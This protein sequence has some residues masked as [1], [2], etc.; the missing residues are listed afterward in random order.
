MLR[1]D[2]LSHVEDE[3]DRLDRR[4][5]SRRRFIGTSAVALAGFAAGC[6]APP[7]PTPGRT[8]APAPAA[9]DRSALAT[10]EMAAFGA[11]FTMTNASSISGD[12]GGDLQAV[13]H[14]ALSIIDH[15]SNVIPMLAER[16]PS[17]D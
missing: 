5:M 2:Q 9:V 13:C 8:T 4:T 10:V 14:S 11:P 7:E 16:L 15:D 12:V 6:S 1:C 17:I 3:M